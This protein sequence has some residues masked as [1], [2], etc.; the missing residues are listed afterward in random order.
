MYAI[1]SYYGTDDPLPDGGGR[2]ALPQ[3]RQLFVGD[4]GHFDMDVDAVEQRPGDTAAVAGDLG[5]RAAAFAAG[6]GLVA[7]MKRQG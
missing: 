1:R 7:A 6:I 2:L 4:R 3:L 5:R